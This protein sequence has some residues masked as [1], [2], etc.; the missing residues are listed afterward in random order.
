MLADELGLGSVSTR[1][2]AVS[3]KTWPGAMRP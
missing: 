1:L 2:G 3:G